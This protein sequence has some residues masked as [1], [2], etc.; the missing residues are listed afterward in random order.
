MSDVER[1]TA[2]CGFGRCG[3]SL[4]M[5]M[6]EAGGL[7][8]YDTGPPAYENHDILGNLDWL[9]RC[10][11]H[12][13]KILDP[14]LIDPPPGLPYRFIW[15]DRDLRQQAGSQIKFLSLFFK[16][17]PRDRRAIRNLAK[18]MRRD[19][20]PNLRLL[21]RISGEDPLILTFEGILTDPP[22]AAA[23]LADFCGGLD[24]GPMAAVVRPRPTDCLS[25]M[26][27]MDMPGGPQS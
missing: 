20:G 16:N 13:V 2:V 5:R 8:P 27:E 19:R 21:R 1:I 25:G 26:L 23:A 7:P 15:L 22:G 24:T 17:I 11:G 14:Q 12:T 6:L 4:V 10:A 3:T 18:G 9:H